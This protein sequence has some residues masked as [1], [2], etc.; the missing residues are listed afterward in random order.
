MPETTKGTNRAWVGTN[1][2]F[3]DESGAPDG[4]NPPREVREQG[5]AVRSL[6]SQATVGCRDTP[7][8]AVRPTQLAGVT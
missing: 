5:G 7:S 4:T 1:R 6:A 3:W 2:D 8:L